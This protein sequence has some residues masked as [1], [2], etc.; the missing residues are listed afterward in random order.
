M[1]QPIRLGLLLGSGLLATLLL[2]NTPFPSAPTYAL[3]Q[4]STR[5]PSLP[6]NTPR[7]AVPVTVTPAT[8]N[9][10]APVVVIPFDARLCADCT[11]VRLRSTPGTAGDVVAFIGTEARLSVL[12]R[13]DDAAW[14]EVQV[15]ATG[16][17]GWVATELVRT[18]NNQP[19]APSLVAALPVTGNA[20]AAPPTP[21]STVGIPAF[22]S[23]ITSTSRRIFLAGQSAGNRAN[24]FVRVGD[25]ITISP[26]FLAEIGNGNIELGAYGALGSVVSFY[27]GGSARNGNSFLT[28][29]IAAGAG[30]ATDQLLTPGYSF[31][32]ICGQ[33]TPIACELRVT[34]PAVALI[35]IGTND[36][37]SGDT[38]RFGAN[39]RTIV[40]TCINAGVIPVL[41]TIPPKTMSDDQAQRGILFN[42]V[43]RQTAQLYDVPLWDYY[44][45]MEQLPAKG[46]SGDGLHPSVPPGGSP[47]R[48]TTENLQY[49]Y[50][51]RNLQALQT[52]DAL[53]R[54]VLY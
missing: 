47:Y 16:A 18:P 50:T 11:R 48:F 12:A 37:G 8:A 54:L 49:G 41:S 36:S 14:L 22:L 40:E 13:S 39:L 2:A 6:T 35:M 33:E 28:T 52:L 10:N 46:M 17:Q 21:T 51:L 1:T 4:A 53:V 27:R 24:V 7:S 38:D 30:W 32:E 15:Q 3:A 5:Q 29:P 34:K 20:V 26:N 9:L 44:F 23:G 45:S 31:G 43:I 42:K 25:S 19:L